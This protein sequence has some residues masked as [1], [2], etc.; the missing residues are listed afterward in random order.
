[1]EVSGQLPVLAILP[2]GKHLQFPLG[3]RLVDSLNWT[4]CSGGEKKKTTVPAR[5]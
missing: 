4:E 3:R 2:L 5:N 1:M